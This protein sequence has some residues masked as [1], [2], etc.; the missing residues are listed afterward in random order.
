MTTDRP[1][2][3]SLPLISIIMPAYNAA[4]FIRTAIE[5]VLAQSWAN[6]E[7]IIVNDGSTDDTAAH[8]ASYSDPRIHMLEQ[9]NQGVAAARNYGLDRSKGDLI[10][11]FDADDRLPSNSLSARA[12]LLL[13][14]PEVDMVDGSVRAWNTHSGALRT[15]HAPSFKGMVYDRLL[16]LDPSVFFGPTWMIRRSAIGTARL[17]TNFTHSEDLAFYITIARGRI[18]ASTPEVVLDYR[19]GHASAMSN[20]PGLHRGY[21]NLLAHVRSTGASA[22][23]MR[24]LDRRIR[25]ILVRSYIKRLNFL[26]ALRTALLVLERSAPK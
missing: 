11:F 26:A 7:L 4:P 16:A 21:A 17:P 1:M 8:V 3:H 5:S 2:A 13:A 14:E 20:L 18:Y 25:S 23:V 24:Y 15:I 12:S 9:T 19:V 22:P 10:V 6:W